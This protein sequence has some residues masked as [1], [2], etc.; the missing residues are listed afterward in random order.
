MPPIN[1]LWDLQL[2][3][4]IVYC[5]IRHTLLYQPGNKAR[6]WHAIVNFRQFV[7]ILKCKT[8]DLACRSQLGAISKLVKLS[9]TME[10]GML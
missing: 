6:N 9:C 10:L 5:K 2:G 3:T 8:F 1:C 4:I 7:I